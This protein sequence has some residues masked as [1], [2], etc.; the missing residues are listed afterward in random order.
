LSIIT[1]HEAQERPNPVSQVWFIIQKICTYLKYN[2][3][4]LILCVLNKYKEKKDK[5]IALTQI[6]K[7]DAQVQPQGTHVGFVEDEVALGVLS[8][9]PA[10][11][12]STHAPYSLIFCL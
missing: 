12:H 10:N 11:Q 9:S 6:L 4:K 8:F 5:T 2:L 7:A 3:T 1:T